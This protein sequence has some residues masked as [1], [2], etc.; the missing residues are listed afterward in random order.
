MFSAST[1]LRTTQVANFAAPAR[2]SNG[3]VS[4]PPRRHV[5]KARVFFPFFVFFFSGRRDG[6]DDDVP[7]FSRCFS[8]ARGKKRPVLSVARWTHLSF[9]PGNGFEKK[10]FATK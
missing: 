7:L 4:K 10:A 5:A 9:Q 1:S 3:K 8:R 6:D 2:T